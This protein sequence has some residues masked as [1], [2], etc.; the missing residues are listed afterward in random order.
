MKPLTAYQLLG[1]LWLVCASA[2]LAAQPVP[3]PNYSVKVAGYVL[4]HGGWSASVGFGYW[5]RYGGLQPATN[6]SVN[7]LGGKSHLGNRDVPYNRWQVN[8][9]ISPML[10]INLSKWDTDIQ[11]RRTALAD[12][13]NP[14]YLGNAGAVY[15]N[16]RSQITIGTSLVLMPKG[17][18]KNI[19]TTR[20]RSQQLVFVQLKKGFDSTRSVELN[21]FD[22]Y[23]G[24]TDTRFFQGL[25]DNRDRYFTGGGNVQVR[26]GQHL[27]LKAYNE[28]YTGNSYVDRFDYPDVLEIDTLKLGT[29]PPRINRTRY[30]YQDPGQGLFNRGRTVF[31][32]EFMMPFAPGGPPI[33]P[34]LINQRLFQVFI[35][36]QEG[37]QMYSQDIIHKLIK[38]DKIRIDRSPEKFS[39][40]LND[41]DHYRLFKPN[42]PQW[43]LLLGGGSTITIH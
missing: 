33:D 6:L 18:D 15:S 8:L 37:N 14:F 4:L 16:Y 27:K 34:L 24:F 1:G 41:Q 10:T 43:R 21:V 31:C 2:W 29:K 42:N 32:A 17:I 11:E 36:K 22:D 35:G 23:L 30:A 3:A 40:S 9:V 26:L 25:A 7:I 13:I 28:I 12:E 19:T 5:Q 38:I 39:T 20:N